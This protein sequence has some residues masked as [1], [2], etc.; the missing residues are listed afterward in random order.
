MNILSILSGIVITGATY[1]IIPLIL[2]GR[3]LE[4]RDEPG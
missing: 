2:K 1:F 3:L 4:K